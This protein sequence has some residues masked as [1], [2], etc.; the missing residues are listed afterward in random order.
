VTHR[1]ASPDTPIAPAGVRIRARLLGMRVPEAWLGWA[2]QDVR[3]RAWPFWQGLAATL[4]GAVGLL[5]ALVAFRLGGE[6]LGAGEVMFVVGVYGFVIA[7][8]VGMAHTES[9]R[10]IRIERLRRGWRAQP[11]TLAVTLL[12]LAWWVVWFL[13]WR[14]GV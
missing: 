4:W 5:L 8:A 2:E 6:S 3:A 9:V 10:R 13:V 11:W 14:P 7:L 1:I 12:V